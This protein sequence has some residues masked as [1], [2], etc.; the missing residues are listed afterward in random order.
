MHSLL[1]PGRLRG[2]LFPMSLIPSCR[3]AA[4]PAGVYFSAENVGHPGPLWRAVPSGV[5]AACRSLPPPLLTQL[6]SLLPQ[7]RGGEAPPAA[8]IPCLCLWPH[9]LLR[10]D[11]PSA[12][13]DWKKLAQ[14]ISS[15]SDLSCTDLTCLVPARRV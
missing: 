14:L 2:R 7:G 4:L 8:A 6:L 13:L 9:A 11:L 15:F 10:S 12:C 3:S 5:R 1:L